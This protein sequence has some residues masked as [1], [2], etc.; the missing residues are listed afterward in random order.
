[1]ILRQKLQQIGRS[2]QSLQK[3]HYIIGGV[4]LLVVFYAVSFFIPRQVEFSYAGQ[5]CAKRLILLP[6][7]HSNTDD[8]YD[9]SF[10]NGPKIGNTQLVSTETCFSTKLSP[11]SGQRVASVAPFNGPF[12]R[13]IFIVNV[14]DA[15]KANVAS[16][17]DEIPV[18]KPL[19]IPLN[20]EDRLHTY[21]L[22]AADQAV[23]CLASDGGLDCDVPKLK[24]AQGQDYSYVLQRSF[25]K[26][27]PS[28]V[29]KGAFR[30]L[31]AVAI[32]D[33]SIK[34]DQT[35]YARPTE[36]T[37]TT[38]KPLK[39]ASVRLLLD[40][41]AIDLDEQVEGNQITVTLDAEL[42][43]EKT[44][45]LIVDS[46]E[47]TDGSNLIEPYA[48]SFTTSGGPKV[49][50]VSVGSS[51]VEQSAAVIL[52]F[53]QAVSKTKDVTPFVSFAGGKA[54]VQKINDT[55]L[56]V[57]LVSLPLCQPFTISVKKGIPSEH[58][59]TSG[60]DWSFTSRTTCYRTVT[61]G[62]SLKGRALNAHI[63]GTSGPV[64]MYVG[65]IHGNEPSSMSLMKA[66]MS[67]LE[68]KP[69]QIAGKRIVVVPS[70]NPDGIAAG[71][72]TNAR[73][74][75]LNRN[76]PTDNWVKSIKDTDGTHPNGGGEK[77]LSEPEAAALAR[78]TTSYSPRLLL[79]FHAVGSLVIGDPGGYSAPYAAKYAS[80]V[81]YRDATNNGA[82]S[83]DYNI[84]GAYEDWTYRN[85][86]IPSMVIELSNYTSVAYSGHY[87]A[88]WSM[89]E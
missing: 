74:V 79:S 51:G 50:S 20:Q 85:V 30:T 26:G 87:K 81:G 52:T 49:A 11:S 23:E 4:G 36:L 9:M 61:Y 38:D 18:S 46:A 35:V 62:S 86:G 34:P 84:S 5:T 76:F 55:Q 27:T 10:E 58:D 80:M 69:D 77:P 67:E 40:E 21:Q 16:V 71:T 17:R 41:T 32:T 3:K 88:L 28:D 53:D 82:G 43:R 73:G 56:R 89:M 33:S 13:T 19:F 7:L 60:Q 70:I 44:F 48:Y 54:S 31:K 42:P 68:S 22:S 78:L 75:N 72:R 1:M 29:A 64:T 63:F 47:A 8:V 12:F 59:I 25:K 65:G 83:F 57:Q 24:L 66:W 6:Q 14:P 15:P 45:R 39:D 2:L 37:I